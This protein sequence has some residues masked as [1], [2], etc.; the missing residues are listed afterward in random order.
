MFRAALQIFS[1]FTWRELFVI[2]SFEQLMRFIYWISEQLI[3][4][5]SNFVYVF[6]LIE[7]P[8]IKFVQLFTFLDYVFELPWFFEYEIE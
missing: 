3:Q 6:L 2:S 7:V 5:I 1:N 8:L 4:T